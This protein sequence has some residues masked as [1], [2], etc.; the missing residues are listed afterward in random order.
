MKKGQ[1]YVSAEK[2]AA[3][4]AAH[5]GLSVTPNSGFI[6]V[7]LGG[8]KLYIGKTKAVGRIDVSG[9]VSQVEG[10]RNLG[11]ESFGQVQQQVSFHRTEDE[12]LATFAELLE[13]MVTSQPV[14]KKAKESA[15]AIWATR[16][17]GDMPS[18]TL[19]DE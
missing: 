12:I 7:E 16:R 15:A 1:T 19:N 9:W 3:L 11:E 13:E 10:L 17:P 4:V 5:P 2:F 6:K 14:P 8:R 18:M